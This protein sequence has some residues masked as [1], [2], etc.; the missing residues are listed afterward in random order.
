MTQIPSRELELDF[1]IDEI[2]MKIEQ[3]VKAS[4]GS[5]Q[6][7]DKNEIFNTYRIASVSGLLSGIISITLTKVSDQKTI[8]KSETTNSVGSKAQSATLAKY[9][10]EF[11]NILAKALSG[12]EIN[13]NLVSSNKAGCLGISIVILVS[14]SILSYVLLT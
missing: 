11:L 9:Q 1:N 6:I 8:W 3:I 13:S 7:L 12:E 2:K 5:Y 14:A 4:T 10:D